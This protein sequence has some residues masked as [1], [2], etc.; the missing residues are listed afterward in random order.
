LAK[1]SESENR[2]E[3][4]AL[5]Q[6]LWWMH[7]LNMWGFATL[8]PVFLVLGVFSFFVDLGDSLWLGG[9]PV[10]TDRQKGAWI[11]CSSAFGALGLVFVWLRRKGYLRFTNPA[12]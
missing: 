6:M 10:R 5:A 7:C 3:A 8:G 9:E 11:V 4:S 1:T 2:D 12:R